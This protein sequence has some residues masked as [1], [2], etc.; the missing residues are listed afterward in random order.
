MN[1]RVQA[2]LAVLVASVLSAG[3]SE[4]APEKAATPAQA[5]AT[6]AAA[7]VTAA[8]AGAPAAGGSEFGVPECD[9]YVKKYQACV[10][11]KVPESARAM[12]RQSFDQSRAAWKQAASTPE[13]RRGLASACAQ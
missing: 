8:P 1:V 4:K 7:P 5:P 6:A 11:S 12:V 10:D 2:G 9:S 13:G 3:C